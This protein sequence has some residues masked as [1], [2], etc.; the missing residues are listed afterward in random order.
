MFGNAY[1]DS[2][3]APTPDN[4]YQL[5]T[6][7]IV[8]VN[9]EARA[10]WVDFWILGDAAREFPEDGW[11]EHEALQVANDIMDEFIKGD[12]SQESIIACRKI[13]QRYLGDNINSSQVYQHKGEDVLVNA[14]GHCHIDTCWLWPFAETKRKIARSW[15]N[16]CELMD[17]YPEHRFVC[18]QGQQFQWLEQL[19]P[20]LYDRVKAKVK[21]GQFIPIGGSWVEHDTNMP[22]G[23][24][25]VR[26]FLYGQR[27]FEGHF[28]A[29]STT[30]WLPDTFGYSSQIPQLCRGAGMTR[31]FTQKLSWN[32]IN[33]FPHTTFN[34]VALDG[35]QVLCHMTPAETY[36]AEAHFGDVNR[37]VTKHKSMDQDPSSLLVFGKGDGGGGPTWQQIE[38]LRRCRGL[39][40]T[41]GRLP[42]VGMGLTVDDFFSSL[43]K[44]A[45]AGTQ[46]VTWYGELYLEFHRG[47]Y[48][49]QANNKLFNR[50]A[51][52][53]LRDIEYFA[54]MASLKDL[55]PGRRSGSYKYPKKELDEMWQRVLQ[56]QFHDCLPGSSINQAY[57]ESDAIYSHVF[58]TGQRIL[59]DALNELEFFSPESDKGPMLIA[60]NNMPFPRRDLVPIISQNNRITPKT[61]LDTP[62]HGISAPL[63]S[64]PR[65]V[66]AARISE[67]AGIFVLE[68]NDLKVEVEK[69]NIISI[70]DRRADRQ[71][72]KKGAKGNQLV[73]FDDKPLSFQAWD[74]EVYHM[75]TRRELHAHSSYISDAGPDRVSVTSET[76]IS[77]KS[78]IKTTVT[79]SASAP[80]DASARAAPGDYVEVSAEADWHEDWKMLKVEFPVDVRNT[81]ASYET[82]Y[83][84]T[85]RPTHYNTTWD[86]AKFEVCSHKFADLSEHGYGVSILNDCKYGFSTRGSIMS[87]SLLRSPKAPDDQA[88][89]GMHRMRWAIMPHV[90]GLGNA[91]VWAARAFNNPV[92]SMPGEPSIFPL[93][94]PASPPS[95][96]RRIQNYNVAQDTM[97]ALR[98]TA[99]SDPIERS[100]VIVDTIK[101]GEDDADVTTDAGRLPVRKGK[102]VIVRLYDSLGGQSR[103]FVRL[104]RLPVGRVVRTNL[105]EDDGEELEI[106]SQRGQ[107]GVHVV[108]KAFEV[109]T[110][111]LVFDA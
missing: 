60:L 73:I 29:R 26:Q 100:S 22:S 64:T 84:I 20:K 35:S 11:E 79:V 80:G 92:A 38:K 96:I 19:Y 56:C 6:A 21:D 9:L 31:F 78:W 10:L 99:D 95:Y 42:K 69:G 70:Y 101:R 32:N 85:Q 71:V 74:V 93:M 51:E 54:T 81:Q 72:L 86:M 89:M 39:A 82:Q 43:Q 34:W 28:G 12:G 68:N 16:Q 88:D 3:A 53:L 14:V 15:S 98:I 58:Q 27:F 94:S 50:K 36:T 7:D 77:E 76:K 30:F 13:A 2:N 110:L 61:W 65:S 17:R 91:T 109:V 5:R 111:R 41:K 48:T 62:A 106:V 23:E 40:D 44:K 24:A 83:G 59:E 63:G 33:T 66:S 46:F 8:A 1:P 107:R 49:T 97:D 108:V 57:R 55:L 87:L 45:D 104:P 67:A 47:T 25:L 105:L 102:S 37:C 18:S 75:E 103:I 52:I 90:G 4:Y